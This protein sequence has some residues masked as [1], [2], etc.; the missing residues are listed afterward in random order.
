MPKLRL[1]DLRL[2]PEPATV[3]EWDVTPD[4]REWIEGE[5]QRQEEAAHGHSQPS[6]AWDF[7]S[8]VRE[9]R[10]KANGGTVATAYRHGTGEFIALN[11]PADV[12]RRLAADRKILAAHPYTTNVINPSYGEHTAGFGCETCHDWDGVPEG[13]GNCTTILA[14]AEGY[15]LEPA[16]DGDVEVIRG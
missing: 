12:L 8:C 7:D 1:A 4:L 13:R 9:V 5:I 10:D 2:I 15:G 11:D 14:L 6:G 16:D 3:A